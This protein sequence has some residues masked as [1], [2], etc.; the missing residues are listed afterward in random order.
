[1]AAI[2][3]LSCPPRSGVFAY[4]KG[5]VM[6]EKAKPSDLSLPVSDL[7]EIDKIC[8]RFEAAW[9]A[10]QNPK[11]DD[12]LGATSGAQR[13]QLHKELSAVEAELRGDVADEPSLEAFCRRLSDSGLM[14]ALEVEQF[15]AG[16][17]PDSRPTTAKQLAQ[18]MHA[19]GKIT[20]FQAQ[21]VYQ[22]KTRG[23]VVGNYVVLDKLGHGGMGQVYTARHRKMHRVVALKMLPSSATKSPDAVKRF[24]REVAAA[25]KLSHPN[26]VTAYDADEAQGVYFLVM[27]YVEGMDLAALVKQRGTLAVSA[28]VDYMLQAARGLEYAHRH[29]VIHRDIKPHNLLI[30]RQRNVKVLDMGL[31]RIEDAVGKVDDVS[32]EGLT[33]TGQVM[34]TL[35]FM[36]PEQALDTRHADARADVYGLGCTLYYL[37]NGRS[38]YRADTVA[39][40]IVAHREHPIPSLREL[41]TDVPEALDA[42]F[43]KMLAKRP[44]D[45]QQSMTEVIAALEKCP[46]EDAAGPLPTRTTDAPLLETR[47]F[48]R[49]DVETSSPRVESTPLSIPLSAPT[50]APLS[51]SMLRQPLAMTERLVSPTR[52]L[53]Q[54]LSKRQ[55]TSLTVVAVL[56]F[57]L[58]LLGIILTMR[59]KDGT[60]VVEVDDPDVTVQVLSEQGK[61]QIERKADKET[62]EISVD[63]GKHGLRI[64]KDGIEVFAKEFTIAS[65]GREI[66]RAKLEPSA[67]ALAVAPFDEKKAKEHQ[68][69][70]AKHLGV[71]VVKTNSI[72]MKLVLIPPGE[73]EMGSSKEFIEEELRLHG[74]DAWYKDHPATDSP[75]HRVRITKPFYLAATEVT[76]EDYER[77]IGKNPS[78]YSS[79]GKGKD[80]VAGQDTK[81]FPVELVSWHEAVEFCRTLS[82]LPGEKAAGRWYR[83][84]SEAQWEYACRA[85][86]P[87]RFSCS[88]G[89]SGIPEEYEEN[90]LSDYAWFDPNAGGRTHPVGQLK[91][92]PFGLYDM[93]GNVWEWCHDRH[94]AYG[95]EAVTDPSGPTT[96]SDRVFRGGS[97]CYAARI[98]RSALRG[99]VAPDYTNATFGFRVVCEIPS[100]AA[101]GSTSSAKPDTGGQDAGGIQATETDSGKGAAIDADRRAAEWATRLGGTVQISIAGGEKEVRSAAEL[102]NSPFSVLGIRVE[103]NPQVTDEGL[104]NLQGLRSIT[105]LR[106]NGNRVT[107]RGMEYLQDL[108]SLTLLDVGYTLITDA[109]LRKLARLTNLDTLFLPG[110][111]VSDAGVDCLKDMKYLKTIEVWNT[112]MSDRG[113]VQLLEEHPSLESVNFNS[114][115]ITDAGLE[116][117]QSHQ[118]LKELSLSGTQVTDAG[119]KYLKNL[120]QL[121]GLGLADTRITGQGLADLEGLPLQVI[122]CARATVTD[123]GI[124]SLKDMKLQALDLNGTL[125]PKQANSDVWFP[126]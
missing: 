5:F 66:I 80:A 35:D 27:E 87:G 114:C 115:K 46:I 109:G 90:E 23:L 112:R 79:T 73:F 62:I 86:N 26:I 50:S 28:A 32:D 16:L 22:G 12:F 84:P 98:C 57:L 20:K 29:G 105:G 116:R 99:S 47:S 124:T 63:P 56:G 118:A 110:T 48:H 68:E 108:T 119:I 100:D 41:R 104:R 61:V 85:G 117:L 14:T 38:P 6:N 126:G 2:L 96:G 8:R 45:R 42:V 59:T 74:N 67:P 53:L 58:V 4:L 76:Q 1:M 81:R 13:S 25:A 52:T 34:G 39:K 93:H 107:D 77:V 101:T 7:M 92:N 94:G 17:A 24:Q 9:K 113:F 3:T 83:L 121:H 10:G 30:D 36:A 44:E 37:L 123:A 54:R 88:L 21:A 102:P 49:A 106:V 111:T 122:W 33:Q 82:Y 125:V 51:A 103:N 75:Q 91:A 55:K 120:K 60:L 64:Q 11:I 89:G 43:Q 31:A 18:E 69:A 78:E 97:L 15:M 40:R 72:G 70:W 95:V 71:P 65:G 19:Q